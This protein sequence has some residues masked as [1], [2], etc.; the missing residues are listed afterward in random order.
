M[1]LGTKIRLGYG[2]V[3]AVMVGVGGLAIYNILAVKAKSEI[4]ANEYTDAVNYETAISENYREARIHLRTFSLGEDKKAYEAGVATLKKLAETVKEAKVL[5][6]KSAHLVTLRSKM[7]EISSNIEEYLKLIDQLKAVN[8][9]KGI[10]RTKIVESGKRCSEALVAL[11][12]RQD[13]A[14]LKD[15]AAKAGEDKLTGRGK[16]L[17]MLNDAIDQMNQIEIA[18]WK[19]QTNS[20]GR[21]EGIKK[22]GGYVE[23]SIATWH[24]WKPSW[25]CRMTRKCSPTRKPL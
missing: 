8:D 3:L 2:G 24:T 1:K 7:G 23:K 21:L 18:I 25:W 13:D 17:G 9:E 12:N 15:I 10:L 6:D 22:L 5:A 11:K 19:L 4:M 14:L 20:E 16:T